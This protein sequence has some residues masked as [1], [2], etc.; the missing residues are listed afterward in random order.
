MLLR[1]ALRSLKYR[2]QSVLLTFIAMV[3]SLSVLFAVEHIRAQIKEV[4]FGVS[5]GRSHY[6]SSNR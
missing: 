5:Q 3:L 1:L 4:L 2:Q 6:R